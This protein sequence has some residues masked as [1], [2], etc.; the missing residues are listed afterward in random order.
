MPILLF[1]VAVIASLVRLY[2]S[3]KARTRA[4]VVEVFLRNF[5]F[6]IFGVG[7]VIGFIY[8]ALMPQS[9]SNF[10]GWSMGSPY[11]AEVGFAD[12]AFGVVGIMTLFYKEV[13]WLASIVFTTIFIWGCSLGLFMYMSANP[14]APD[15]GHIQMFAW[16]NFILPLIIIILFV[17]HLKLS[18]IRLK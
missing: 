17:R 13:F 7:G 3:K 5:L 16:G 14:A 9:V 15:M 8:V 11:Q 18:K 12:L 6:F 1:V 2:S 10:I 4:R